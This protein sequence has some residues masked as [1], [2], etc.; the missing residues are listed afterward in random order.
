MEKSSPDRYER[1]ED[2][3]CSLEWTSLK[4]QWTRKMM[5]SD[6]LVERKLRR[7][8]QDLQCQE[9]ETKDNSNGIIRVCS[10]CNTTR[11]PLWRS[12]PQGP[13]VVMNFSSVFFV[14]LFFFAFIEQSLCNA[15]GI[16]QR[17]ARRAMALA[18]A[19]GAVI[20]AEK[21]IEMERN[22]DCRILPYKK[23]CRITPT[24]KKKV[25]F[26]DVIIS[27]NNNSAFHR[28]FPQDEKDAAILLMGLSCGL[29]Q[30]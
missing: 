8:K 23:R 9:Q 10:N 28:V 25:K 6:Q 30:N 17:K 7:R 1:K 29:I 20:S 12:G 19:G 27:L 14:F 24:A 13:K 2:V 5:G 26:E 18:A 22:E 11:T 4:M 21:P 15:C 3:H 16:R